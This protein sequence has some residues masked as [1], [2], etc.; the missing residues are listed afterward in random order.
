MSSSCSAKG[1]EF[2]F[3][4]CWPLDAFFCHKFQEE[5]SKGFWEYI[6]RFFL[7]LSLSLFLS[8]SPCNYVPF[9]QKKISLGTYAKVS[10]S[11]NGRY[12]AAIKLDNRQDSKLFIWKNQ[13]GV[14][15]FPFILIRVAFFLTSTEHKSCP[16]QGIQIVWIQ[17]SDNRLRI[18]ST[19][20]PLLFS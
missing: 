13:N 8:T 4:L 16:F 11:K 1:R 15:F 7:S 2:L 12:L 18:S 6:Q 19:L 17:K 10:T 5:W 9:Q 14:G 3:H 20:A